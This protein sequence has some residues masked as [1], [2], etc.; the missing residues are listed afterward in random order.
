MRL[1]SLSNL[2]MYLHQK[3]TNWMYFDKNINGNKDENILEADY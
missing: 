3:D 2:A 1:V